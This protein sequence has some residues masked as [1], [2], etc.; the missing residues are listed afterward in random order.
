MNPPYSQDVLQ[1][2]KT[3]IGQLNAVE[4]MLNEGVC[5]TQ[6]ATQIAAAQGL[7]KKAVSLIAKDRMDKCLP[8]KG[9]EELSQALQV[10]IEKT[11]K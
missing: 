11:N 5:C 3:A 10:L 8:S 1:M 9:E 7:M 2:V 4:R 6:V